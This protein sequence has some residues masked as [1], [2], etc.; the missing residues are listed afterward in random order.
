MLPQGE[1]EFGLAP[2]QR[3]VGSG[4]RPARIAFAIV[5]TNFPMPRSLIVLIVVLVLL[6]AGLFFLAGRDSAQ[7]PVRIEKAVPLDNLSQ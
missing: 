1:K 5:W 3:G 6:V 7:E 4:K 2:V